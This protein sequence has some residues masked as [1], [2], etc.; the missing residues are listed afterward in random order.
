MLA[1]LKTLVK[2]ILQY[3]LD[4]PIQRTIVVACGVA[5][6]A[7]II[8]LIVVGSVKKKQRNRQQAAA[9]CANEKAEELAAEEIV[10]AEQAETAEA[11]AEQPVAEQPAEEQATAPETTAKEQPVEE[12]PTEAQAIAPAQPK[13]EKATVKKAKTASEKPTTAKKASEAKKETQTTKKAEPKPTA[14]AAEKKADATAKAAEKKQTPVKAATKQPSAKYT[15]KWVI[16]QLSLTDSE[17]NVAEENYFFELRASN[18]ERLLVSEEYTSHAGAIKGIQTHKDNV[19]KGNFRITL[20]KKGDYIFK[21]LTAKNTLLCTGANYK[22]LE[23]C[24]RAIAST[25][26]FA[27]TAVVQDE[28]EEI[29]MS[30]PAEE[31]TAQA[32]IQ[33]PEN[34]YTGKW[35]INTKGNEEVG[36][37]YYFELFASNGEKL[38]TSEEYTTYEG[39]VNAVATHKANIAKGN[40]RITITKRGDYLFKLLGGNGQLL[41]MGEHY[42]T[43]SRCESAV[44]SV[45]R[46]SQSAPV[47]KYGEINA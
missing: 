21:L 4:N 6:V 15:G 11:A 13:K 33:A 3:L 29:R 26:R 31:E 27:A 5:I 8:T 19:E 44:E 28:M 12:Q 9:A 7:L 30:L 17:G 42:K 14:K 25:K 39:A 24:E 23:R 20:S 41:C 35:I 36:I 18:G 32:E 16:C 38:L 10:P 37:M 46:F 47:Y 43:R 40:F 34:G 45:K 22:S 1:K 2:G